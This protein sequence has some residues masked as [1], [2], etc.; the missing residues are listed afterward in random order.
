MSI[1]LRV[2]ACGLVGRTPVACGI[3]SQVSRRDAGGLSG[4]GMPPEGGHWHVEKINLAS[5]SQA[6]EQRG[7]RA[8]VLDRCPGHVIQHTMSPII[9]GDSP[10]A[11]LPLSAIFGDRAP[12]RRP[13][14]RSSE[15]ST[16]REVATCSALIASLSAKI[17]R[18]HFELKRFTSVPVSGGDRYRFLGELRSS[19]R[20]MQPRAAS[21]TSLFGGVGP[22]PADLIAACCFAIDFCWGRS[23]ILRG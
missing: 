20:A 23:S 22:R 2:D 18:P 15:T 1:D 6:G 4:S 5:P 17:T 3:Y 9:Q 11:G 8:A 13:R 7:T 21:S 19:S 16:S 14:Q 10:L 12:S